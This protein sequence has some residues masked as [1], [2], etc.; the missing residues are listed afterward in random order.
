MVQLSILGTKIYVVGSDEFISLIERKPKVISSHSW[1]ATWVCAL[2]GCSPRS[3][4]KY[5]THRGA[6]STGDSILME[7]VRVT[8]RILNSQT[9]VQL[10]KAA[11]HVVSERFKDSSMLDD[12]VLLDL[13]EWIKHEIMYLVSKSS[14]GPNNP[15]WK[16]EVQKAF[17]YVY[18]LQSWRIN[19]ELV[20]G[21][22][23][24][25]YSL[26][27]QQAFS[28]SSFVPR[29]SKDTKAARSL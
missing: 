14:Y 5:H 6:T 1:F 20:L 28:Q 25:A 15:F 3:V 9:G 12:G 8:K 29:S 7:G 11:A 4:N 2:V 13:F 24:E 19:S 27:A 16:P 17:W 23:K 22:S 26:S 18:T 21:I 10:N